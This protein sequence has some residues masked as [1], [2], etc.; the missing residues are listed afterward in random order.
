MVYSD[1]DEASEILLD[2]IGDK[3]LGVDV[4]VALPRGGVFL[5]AKLADYYDAR[6]EIV[7]VCS[8]R[9][10]SFPE[11][12]I[13]AVAD[14]GTMWLDK[15]MLDGIDASDKMIEQA[16]QNSFDMARQ[17]LSNYGP[18]KN[19][20]FKGKKILL[21][22]E[23]ASNSMN[24]MAAIGLLKKRNVESIALVLPVAPRNVVLDV[25]N[26]VDR[27]LVV[28][29]PRF[30]CSVEDYFDSLEHLSEKKVKKIINKE[31]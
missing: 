6:L 28:K 18:G 25:N 4:V 22:D 17:E 16:R 1:R 15:E 23:G 14:D 2:K 19:R 7:A 8:L 3:D 11:F 10:E 29:Q 21:V 31:S 30:L 5:G 20:R 12:Q 27:S 9:L 13:G 26:I 24:L